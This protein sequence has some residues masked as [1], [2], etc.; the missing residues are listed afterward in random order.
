MTSAPRA[1]VVDDEESIRFVVAQELRAHKFD[2]EV[3]DSG[4]SALDVIATYQPDVI[5]LDIMLPDMDGFEL[6]D[7]LRASGVVAPV[8]FLT[9]RD[10]TSDRV[11]GLTGGGTDYVTKPFALAE[12]VARVKLRLAEGASSG[13]RRLR[14]ADLMLDEELHEVTRGGHRIQ[15]S[16]TEF[17]LLRELLIGQGRVL[18]RGQLLDLVWD[19][20]FDGDAAIVDKYV[21]Y[22][23]H[24]IDT[25]DHK[26]I[27]TVRG[28]GFTIRST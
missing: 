16:P 28:V 25:V 8:L 9:A 3:A 13:D 14:C 17:R 22:L 2:V 15:L 11:R 1:V 21:S 23:R 24:K 7:R 4:A 27:H 5:V 18:S 19:F 6:L 26:L 12:L 20:A 10:G